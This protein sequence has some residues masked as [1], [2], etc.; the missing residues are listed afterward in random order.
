MNTLREIKANWLKDP[1]VKDV[2]EKLAPEFILAKTLIQARV[3]AGLT[4]LQ[5]AEKMG[6][7][8]S[9]IARLESGSSLPSIKSL[10]RYAGAVGAKPV[11]QLI[12]N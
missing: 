5:V 8:Q 12:P 3:N 11:I 10:Y 4:Q 2:Y 1:A 9:A 7:T 6:T